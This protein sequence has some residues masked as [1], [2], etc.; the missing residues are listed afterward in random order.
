MIHSFK[1][2][3]GSISTRGRDISSQVS[4]R[5]KFHF[6]TSILNAYKKINLL[7]HFVTLIVIAQCL[8]FLRIIRTKSMVFFIYHRS[9][10]K[11]A[12]KMRLN[13]VNNL[14]YVIHLCDEMIRCNIS[15]HLITRLK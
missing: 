6:V 15:S 4:F 7:L 10:K 1:M 14:N 13:L 12:L 8:N 2:F 3:V 9:I 11:F 5:H